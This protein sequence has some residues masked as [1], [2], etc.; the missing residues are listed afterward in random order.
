MT[1]ESKTER[2]PAYQVGTLDVRPGLVLSPMSGVTDTAFR[3]LVKRASGDSVGLLVTEF[4][5]VEGLSRKDLRTW[6]RLE[7]TEEERPL[8]IQIFGGEPEKMALAAAVA[9]DQGADALDVNCGCPS[10][11][12]VRKGGGADLHRDLPRLATIL[13]AVKAAVGDLPLSMKMRSGWDEENLNALDMA[14]V[15]VDCGVEAVAV[16]GRTRVQLYRGEA[17]W[18]V[19][20]EL[21]SELSIPVLGSGDIALPEDVPRLLKQTGCAGVMVGRAA[22]G[23][24]WIFRQIEDV[25]EGREPFCPGPPD[26]IGLVEEYEGFL[27]ERL[28]RKALPGRLKQVIAR[29]CKRIPGTENLRRDVLRPDDPD[30][31][32]DQ[33]RGFMNERDLRGEVYDLRSRD[34]R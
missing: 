31:L 10:P 23:N 24:P 34:L 9:V 29:L 11:R 26:M 12:V 13:K 15:A 8:C 16:H 27:K 21:V 28:P 5:S 3:R 22:I 6:M 18:S 2:V 14:R 1:G 7:S 17:D 20:E 33:F 19:V 25:L 4:V 32:M 30:E